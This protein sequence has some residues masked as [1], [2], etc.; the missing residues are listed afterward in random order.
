MIEWFK[1]ATQLDVENIK[2]KC[3]NLMSS[4]FASI[5]KETEFL[6]L[7]L[8]E[9]A[10]YIQEAQEKEVSCDDLLKASL[11]WTNYDAS[12]RVNSLQDLLSH[13]K[14][15]NCTVEVMKD[16]MEKYTDL[17]DLKPFIVTLFTISL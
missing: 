15:E 11:T 2:A 17:L 13:I 16:V 7:T 5:T 12:S 1:I 4:H 10:D 9:V 6:A 8:A 3:I 14:L